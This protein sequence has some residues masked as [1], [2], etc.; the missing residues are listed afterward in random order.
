MSW[1]NCEDLNYLDIKDL[2]DI[3][4]TILEKTGGTR[5]IIS[6][7]TLDRCCN[8]PKWKFFYTI[9]LKAAALMESIIKEHPFADG[10]KRTAVSAVHIFLSDN[11]IIFSLP[12]K[13]EVIKLC[14][15]VANCNFNIEE[16][17][18]WIELNSR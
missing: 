7:G 11:G 1:L 10:N 14:L 2:I 5:G 17:S 16:L 8:R 13:K 3:H 15:D 12:S 4:D 9:T 6:Y 18:K